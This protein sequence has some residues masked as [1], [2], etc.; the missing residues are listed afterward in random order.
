MA[1]ARGIGEFVPI[2]EHIP[3][4]LAVVIAL[5]TQLGDVWL[6]TLLV[7]LV[8]WFATDDRE[9]AVAIVGLTVA[10]LAALY[11]LKHAFGLPRPDQPLVRL[12]HLPGMVQP[13]YAVTGT[14]SG[15]GFPSGHAFMTTIVYLRLA[16]FLSVRTRSQ[17]YLAAGA[18]I[19]AV[20]FSRVALGVHYLV[21]VV[22][23]VTFA[24]ILL[25]A[26]DGMRVRWPYDHGTAVLGLA[27]FAS[28]FTLAAFPPTADT[29]LLLGAALGAFGG[30]QLIVLGNRLFPLD[31]ESATLRPLAVRGG[32]AAAALGPLFVAV[33]EFALLSLPARGGGFGL[34]VAAFVTVPVL[35]HSDRARTVRQSLAFWAAMAGLGLRR[36][37]SPSTWQQLAAVCREG[38]RRV[39]RWIRTRRSEFDWP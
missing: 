12:E 1:G 37:S 22:A 34:L 25:L 9:D 4:W 29:V 10:G 24:V 3:E 23:G 39:R 17:R 13:L 15:Y 32:L 27:I 26:A 31:R 5:I 33:D 20:C 14:A 7:G 30:W 11:G 16:D 35:R 18:I 2:Q 19:V 38:G 6:L 36:L 28:G 8:Y 21:D